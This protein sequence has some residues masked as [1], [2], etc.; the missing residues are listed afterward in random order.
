[1][2]EKKMAIYDDEV[3]LNN[4]IDLRKAKNNYNDLIEQPIVFDLLRN[5]KGKRILDIGCGY[6]AMT[7]KMAD[8]GADYVLGIDISE[9]MIE[10]GF[11]E[12]SRHNVEY[13]V[14]SATELSSIKIKFDIV[15]SC[16]AIHY[17]E[18]FG[19]LFLD[20]YNVINDNGEFV[21][22]MEH[23]MYTASKLPQKWITDPDS[24]IA[25][26]FVTDHYGEEG[27]RNLEWLGKVVTKYHHKIETVINSLIN[28]GF[29]IEK[30]IEPSPNVELIN[31]VPKTAHEL[32]RPAYLI[33][34]CKKGSSI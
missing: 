34:K 31:K 24:N 29:L 23:P 5:I 16:L 2:S 33:I 12:N 10:K 22:S 28:S 9:K 1:M 25:T 7:V 3:F 21:F 6:G 18:D 26:G 30:V 15:V 27:I 14:L 20:V 11:I 32:H 4:Y 17:I 19:K 13:K 8:A